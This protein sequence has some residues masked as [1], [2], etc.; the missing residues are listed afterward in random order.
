M[1]IYRLCY[2]LIVQDL[3]VGIDQLLV[4]KLG[5]IDTNSLIVFQD[6]TPSL[7]QMVDLSIIEQVMMRRRCK[8]PKFDITTERIVVFTG[9]LLW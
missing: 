4:M 6:E 7:H 1:N 8:V 2:V 5:Q 9:S 3:Q